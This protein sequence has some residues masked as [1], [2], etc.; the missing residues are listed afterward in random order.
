MTKGG[1][2]KDE[3]E[4]GQGKSGGGVQIPPKKD[5]IIYEQSL[6]LTDTATTE[7]LIF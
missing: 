6:T 5:Y 4:R 2:G 7:A 3:G 1:E